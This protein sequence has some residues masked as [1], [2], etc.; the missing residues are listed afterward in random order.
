MIQSYASW[1]GKP[2]GNSLS[3]LRAVRS[4][5]CDFIKSGIPEPELSAKY[6][7]L[8]AWKGDSKSS[9][10]DLDAS[11]LDDIFLSNAQQDALL[12]LKEKRLKRLSVQHCVEVW[13]FHDIT[14][15]LKP[16]ILVPRPETEVRHNECLEHGQ[17]LETYIHRTLMRVMKGR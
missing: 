7:V 14:L 10:R 6:L 5:I 3:L 11:N 1:S 8:H 16:P 15:Q 9:L 13:D 12:E 4:L 17:G 2:K